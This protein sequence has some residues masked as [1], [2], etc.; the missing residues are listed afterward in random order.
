MKKKP[1][2]RKGVS[3]FLDEHKKLGHMYLLIGLIECCQECLDA[4]IWIQYSLDPN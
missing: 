2:N 1:P 4:H 3:I